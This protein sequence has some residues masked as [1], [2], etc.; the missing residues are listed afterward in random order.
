MT[1]VKQLNRVVLLQK[2]TLRQ[3]KVQTQAQYI[4]RLN[5]Q[6]D[7][8]QIMCKNRTGTHNLRQPAQGVRPQS[9]Q[10]SAPKGQDLIRN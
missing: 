6:F 2:W 7:D 10:Q 1:K 3:E 9:L 4:E 8:G 5:T